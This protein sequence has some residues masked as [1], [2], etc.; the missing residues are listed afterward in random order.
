MFQLLHLYWWTFLK[1]QWLKYERVGWMHC[2]AY[3]FHQLSQWPF[4]LY[5]ILHT[6]YHFFHNKSFEC[7]IWSYPHFMLMDNADILCHNKWTILTHPTRPLISF[8]HTQI[9]NRFGFRILLGMLYKGMFVLNIQYTNHAISKYDNF[10]LFW[11]LKIILL[12]F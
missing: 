10:Q 1:A 9:R 3:T 11:F 12:K 6:I 5:S 7:L 2:M 8:Y 4:V